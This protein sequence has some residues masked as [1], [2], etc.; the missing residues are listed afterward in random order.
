MDRWPVCQA[1]RRHVR[2]HE[3]MF[4]YKWDRG[5]IPNRASRATPWRISKY[6]DVYLFLQG[7]QSSEKKTRTN[8]QWIVKN[9]K[10]FCGYWP[11]WLGH[12]IDSVTTHFSLSDAWWVPSAS[13]GLFI[14]LLLINDSTFYSWLYAI[15]I[16]Y[17][18]L[19]NYF[20]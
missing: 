1:S 15:L 8:G 14:Y 5:D 4:F 17:W 20:I 7:D 11:S 3:L 19:N 12:L 6:L 10:I 18:R 9:G 16:I 2:R 13:G